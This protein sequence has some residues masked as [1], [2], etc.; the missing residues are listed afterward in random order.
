MSEGRKSLNLKLISKLMLLS[1]LILTVCFQPAKAAPQLQAIDC[2]TQGIISVLECEALVALYISTNGAAWTDY[3]DW[4]VGVDPCTWFGVTCTGTD[5]TSLVLENNNLVGN[6][7][8]EI[9]DLTNLITLDLSG[10]SLDSSIPTQIGT[11]T[12]L[13]TV[14]LSNNDLTGALPTEIGNLTALISLDIS[15]NIGL[16]GPLPATM[17]GLFAMTTL[18]Y[19]GTDLCEP[20]E[21]AFL[22]WLV[23]VA[24]T[25]TGIRCDI[26]C[27]NGEP[28]VTQAECEA[29]EALYN[30]TVGDSWN[31][32]TDWL[33]TYDVCSWFGVTCGT[34]VVEQLTL[35]GN[36]L[37]GPLPVEIGDLV[38]LITVDLSG[39]SLTGSIPTTIGTMTALETVDL[40]NNQLSG[41]LPTEIGNLTALITL[42]ISSNAGLT[43]PLPA[44]MTSLLAL[45]SFDYSSTDLCEPQE[46]AFQ[47]WIGTINTTYN[48]TGV[49]CQIDCT[50][51]EPTV[52]QTECE[53]LEALYISTA[54]DSWTDKNNW[55]RS[56]DVE[57][58][59][60]ITLS[61]SNVDRVLLQNN[62][63]DGTLPVE[64]G[65]LTNL[66]ML[67]LSGNLL[68]GGI[69]IEIGTLT[70][71]T[72]FDLSDNQLS[73][74][75]PD[76]VGN[77]LL[78]MD[79]IV[80]DNPGLSGPLPL[81]LMNINNS[82]L[83]RFEFN[84]TA[85]CEP[86]DPGFQ[87]WITGGTMTVISTNLPCYDC[88][89]E[90][91]PQSQCEALLALYASTD[92]KNWVDDSNW[93][94]APVCSPWYGVTCNPGNNTVTEIILPYN[95]L[96]GPIPPEIGDFPDLTI[97][98]LGGSPISGSLP[99][100]VGNLAN[101]TD[102]WIFETNITGSLPTSL[103]NLSQLDQLWIYTNSINGSIPASLGNL[104]NLT[105]LLL[106]DNQLSGTIPTEIGNLVW[107]EFLGVDFNNLNGSLP[108][109]IGNLTF[110]VG[111]YVGDN[112]FS[113][114]VP[115]SFI[116]LINLTEFTTQNTSLCLPNSL[117]SWYSN[118]SLKTGMS[119]CIVSPTSTNTPNPTATGSG[120]G[121]GSEPTGTSLPTNTPTITFTPTITRTP[122]L[123]FPLQTLTQM[124]WEDTQA[125]T[126]MSGFRTAT[127]AATATLYY[128]QQQGT[129]TQAAI[130]A[131]GEGEG[132]G[133]ESGGSTEGGSQS[134]GTGGGLSGAL[135]Q[136][137]LWGLGAIVFI[138]G[139]IGLF[140]FLRRRK[141]DEDGSGSKKDSK[142]QTFT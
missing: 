21:A 125:A 64:I 65:D 89:A 90:T 59:F 142:F 110:L 28:T 102:L 1:V 120:S 67:N 103:G 130:E 13:E 123:V 23:G 127:L 76:E 82:N 131:T 112:N 98:V 15:T 14:D 117:A 83:I 84:G 94:I 99:T 20:Q 50:N 41:A 5:V 55:L 78:L 93:F 141:D 58:W 53:A 140:I 118:L 38:N 70:Q 29:L 126:S 35:S 25:G 48:D 77:L 52:S 45:D 97:L 116:N 139:G 63:L 51:G 66:T 137:M 22:A 9:G 128:S 26:D 60:G 7:P 56:Y 87:N 6:L 69:P 91:I 96:A 24:D 27:T 61:G 81:T 106:S 42:D 75:L 12:A 80:A 4:D 113:G 95:D 138:G 3:T 11:M 46:S 54:G 37:D 16:T 31:T 10:N 43:G 108:S 32:K 18:T 104:S 85:L 101:L 33:K 73:G 8:V 17:T 134:G 47:S 135:S 100:E 111:L 2:N 40:S 86:A 132:S 62:N 129:Q 19:T 57:S 136:L 68:T 133:S 107:L 92:G 115:T 49:N 124:A 72:I 36:N 34:G 119:F 79:L 105:V 88:S 39:N 121:G 44:A 109:Q 71:L 122:T 74:A 114:P 30:N